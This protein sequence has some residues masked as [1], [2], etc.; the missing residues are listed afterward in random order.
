METLS[1]SAVIALLEG[2]GD[3]VAA[4]VLV[5]AGDLSDDAIPVARQQARP[6]SAALG[7]KYSMVRDRGYRVE[8]LESLVDALA[9]SEDRYVVGGAFARGEES[10]LIVLDEARQRVVGLLL[11]VPEL[12]KP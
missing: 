1:V 8:G 5:I 6:W 4:A 7:V 2:L 10:C 9:R 3:P 12:G 11:I